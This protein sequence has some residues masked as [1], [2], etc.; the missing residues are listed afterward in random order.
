M[1]WSIAF[2]YDVTELAHDRRQ[3]LG[4]DPKITALDDEL[5]ALGEP[6]HQR[7]ERRQHD[8]ARPAH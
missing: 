8:A 3:H 1:P 5:D 6:R 7:L 4:I 2:A